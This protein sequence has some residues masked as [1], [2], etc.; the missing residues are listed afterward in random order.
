MSKQIVSEPRYWLYV[1]FAYLCLLSLGFMDNTRGAVFEDFIRDLALS[2]SKASWFFVIPSSFAFLSSLFCRSWIEKRGPVFM[3]RVGL[4]LMG[5]ATF[6]FGCTQSFY[7]ILCEATLFGIGFGIISVAQNVAISST[8]RPS[9]QRQIF[10]GLHGMYGLASLLAPLVAGYLFSLG[11]HWQGIFLFSVIIPASVLVLL[12]LAPFPKWSEKQVS[13]QVHSNDLAS[14]VR[15]RQMFLAVSLSIYLV[16]EI[17]VSSRLVVLVQR[18]LSLPPENATVYLMVFFLCLFFSRMLFA[19]AKLEGLSTKWLLQLCLWGSAVLTSA[20]LMLSP[21]FLSL[22]ALTMAPFFPA[23]MDFLSKR[24]GTQAHVGMAYTMAF[25][26][27]TVV[28]MHFLVG[29]LTDYYGIGKALWVAPISLGASSLLL[30]SEEFWF[31]G[32]SRPHQ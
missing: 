20:G 21:W 17:S 15:K 10:S 30:L 8:V 25:A 13:Q 1:I 2:D 11:V 6:S 24:F 28:G 27:L 9:Y 19:F 14:S 12:S 7:I 18:S 5:L 23:A 3:L 4:A 26:S 22:S 32:G 31:R 16:A 29:I